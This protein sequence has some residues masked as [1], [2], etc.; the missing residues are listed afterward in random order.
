[1]RPV[2]DSGNNDPINVGENFIERRGALRRNWIQ[3]REDFPWP[4]VWR[5]GTRRDLLPIICNPIGYAVK[6]LPKNIRRNV[7]EFRSKVVCGLLHSFCFYESGLWRADLL[8]V[9]I[10]RWFVISRRSVQFID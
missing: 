9:G 7:T 5:N 4:H 10:W 3:L 2:R 1:M 6:M 8:S